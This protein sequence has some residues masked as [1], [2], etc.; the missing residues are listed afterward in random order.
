MVMTLFSI[1]MLVVLSYAAEALPRST[2]QVMASKAADIAKITGWAIPVIAGMPASSSGRQGGSALR[3]SK[4][5]RTTNEVLKVVDGIRHKR[6]GGSDIVV[7]EIGLG[8]QRWMGEDFNS[9]DEKICLDFLDR[10]ILNSG[11]NLID[12]AEQ[13]PI[14]SSNSN[15]EGSTERVI[16]KWYVYV[17]CYRIS[18]R[19][20]HWRANNNIG[21]LLSYP[22]TPI[23]YNITNML[24]STFTKTGSLKAKADEKRW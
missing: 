3:S 20:A 21:L 11:V 2:R 23:A 5:G 9:P 15:P 14:P 12:T 18:Y 4:T 17:L 6:L 19:V 16:G 7:S 22:T 8:T 10:A 13:Y 24:I 1:M